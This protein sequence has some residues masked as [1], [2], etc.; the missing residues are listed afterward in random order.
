MTTETMPQ[1]DQ[2]WGGDAP[3]QDAPAVTYPEYGPLP[4]ARISLNFTPGKAP[5]LTARAHTPSELKALLEELDDSGVYAD[6]GRAHAS[7]TAGASLGAG[8]GAT[9]ISNTPNAPQA[10][11]IPQMPAQ[12]QLPAPPPMGM[13]QQAPQMPNQPYA[14]QPAW[15]QAGAPQGPSLPPGW[16]KLDVPFKPRG[17]NPGKPGFDQVI[18]QYG[19]RKGDPHGGGQV[20]FQKEVKTWYCAGDVAGAFAQFNPVPA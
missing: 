16:Y 7:M 1:Q 19:L 9:Q 8:V 2:S 4:E 12:G 15:Q 10:P 13:P 5:Q 14:G 3:A 6:L 17:N 20:S 11:Q 18:A